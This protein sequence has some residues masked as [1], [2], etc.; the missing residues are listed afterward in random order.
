MR[1]PNPRQWLAHRRAQPAARGRRRRIGLAALAVVVVFAA[2]FAGGAW[3]AGSRG[4]PARLRDL[5]SRNRVLQDGLL[6]MQ[7]EH[8][9]DQAANKVLQQTLATR[10]QE[11]QKL[12]ADQA[13]Y[14]KLIGG[15]GDQ[16]GLAVHD[17]SVK[18]MAGTRA[19][20]FVVTLTNAA[21]GADTTRGTLTIAV[22]GVH[23]G[24]LSVA[25]WA[26]LAGP[27]G[28]RG[29]PFS[30]KFFQQVRGTLMLPDGFTPNRLLVSVDPERGAPVTRRLAWNDVVQDGRGFADTMP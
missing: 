30:F 10:D 28:K 21:T 17:V 24:K 22:E 13:F 3:L 9:T 23:D 1:V 27:D 12:R 18:P 11:L 16:T 14:A 8:R 15:D 20:N 25:D 26:T 19:W 7:R 6:A 2:G 29:L 5:T 4:N